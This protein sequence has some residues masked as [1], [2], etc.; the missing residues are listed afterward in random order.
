MIR[1]NSH[2]GPVRTQISNAQKMNHSEMSTQNIPNEYVY[3]LYDSG[4]KSRYADESESH[5]CS[6]NEKESKMVIVN[7]CSSDESE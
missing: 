4:K 6:T 2:V 3:S 1:L 5:V 7:P